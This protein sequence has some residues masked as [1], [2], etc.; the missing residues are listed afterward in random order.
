V[1]DA[2]DEFLD[3]IDRFEA[4]DVRHDVVTQGEG[5]DPLAGPL[6]DGGVG[7]GKPVVLHAEIGSRVRGRVASD[8]GLLLGVHVQ[9]VVGGPKREVL[10]ASDRRGERRGSGFRE[11]PDRVDVVDDERGPGNRR[12]RR[13]GYRSR[14]RR[15]DD[16]VVRRGSA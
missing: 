10:H 1:A 7:V 6:D 15:P 2:L 11:L 4:A 3:V 12:Y 5:V 9:H 13:P 14:S 16:H 8:A